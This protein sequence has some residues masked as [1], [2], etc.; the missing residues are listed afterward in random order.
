MI[1]PRSEEEGESKA[2]LPHGFDVSGLSVIKGSS[3]V[4]S[5]EKWGFTQCSYVQHSRINTTF[6]RFVIRAI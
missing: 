1:S 4:K 6:L 3:I 2:Q 5:M